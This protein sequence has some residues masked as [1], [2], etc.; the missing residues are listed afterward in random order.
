[1]LYPSELRGRPNRIKGFS[2]PRNSGISLRFAGLCWVS[3]EP[4]ATDEHA[5]SNYHH[6]SGPPVMKFGA[7]FDEAR[8]RA[9]GRS[10][11]TSCVPHRKHAHSAGTR[12]VV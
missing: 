5:R 6:E 9:K 10:N 3:T 1:V 4:G 11:A 2:S 7:F 12:D 8:L